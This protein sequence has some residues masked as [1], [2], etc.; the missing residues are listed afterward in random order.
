MLTSA[1]PGVFAA[2][3]AIGVLIVIV[4]SIVAWIFNVISSK[5]TVNRPP[6]QR[7][8]QPPR[9][10]DDRLQDE[11]DIFIKEVSPKRPQASPARGLAPAERPLAPNRSTP[12][13]DPNAGRNKRRKPPKPLVAE[14]AGPTPKHRPP[15][16]EIASRSAPGT[17]N[18]GSAIRQQVA[19]QLPEHKLAREVAADLK[20]RIDPDV[21]RHL[22][23][24]VTSPPPGPAVDRP[25]S[26]SA[27]SRFAELLRRP[28]SVRDAIL[29][30]TILSLPP[31]R[32]SK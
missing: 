7:P 31:G 11:I 4:I 9:P 27:A 12:T 14:G 2:H 3:D 8:R 19:E 29:I 1:V 23:E 5:A 10:R 13:A 16:S 17:G 32:K 30:N 15:G 18:L 25:Q 21:A 6:A 26:A 28:A 24:F 20:D 22:G